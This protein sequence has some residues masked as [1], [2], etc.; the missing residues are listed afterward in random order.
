MIKD[1][2]IVRFYF[3]GRRVGPILQKELRRLSSL[4]CKTK[5][6]DLGCGDGVMIK[7]L[8]GQNLVGKN[9]ELVGLDI[10]KKNIKLCRRRLP[11]LHFVVGKAENILFKA[12]SFDFIYSWMVIEHIYNPHKMV[13]ETT[14]L[15]K[16]GGKCYISSIVKRPWAIYF[17]R[18]NGKFVL[19]PT[20]VNEFDS[21]KSFLKLFKTKELRIIDFSSKLR[22][23]SIVE[24]ILKVLIKSK[25]LRSSIEL[26]DFF[27]NNKLMNFVKSFLIIPV[28]GF[29]QVEVLHEKNTK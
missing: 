5:C 19:D 8:Y 16:N 15:L 28:P 24:L 1:A 4:N 21:E 26:R 20:H 13:A 6:L 11:D 9:V 2:T 3:S 25:I 23:Y 7:D 17:Y 27:V 14:R 29:Y 10:S 12:K 18:N 22:T